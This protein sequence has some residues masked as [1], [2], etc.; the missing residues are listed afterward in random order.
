MSLIVRDN[1]SLLVLTDPV[2]L[3]APPEAPDFPPSSNLP[4]L[5]RATRNKNF[6]KKIGDKEGGT[7]NIQTKT[8]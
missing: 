6:I 1:V 8:N 4:M 3:P 5:P 7:S 2:Y